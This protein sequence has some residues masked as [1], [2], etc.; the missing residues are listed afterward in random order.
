[1][2]AGPAV[3]FT[4]NYTRRPGLGAW[5]FMSPLLLWLL[6]FVIVPTVMIV[7]LSFAERD[8]LG[9][10]VWNLN[11]QNYLRAVDWDKMVAL[12]VQLPGN[13]AGSTAAL[14]REESG[15]ALDATPS[16][17]APCN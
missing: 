12:P 9:R 16:S 6:L 15:T 8:A 2:A 11:I 7:L 4:G 3:P 1:M 17:N 5:L 13:I 14:V 10:T